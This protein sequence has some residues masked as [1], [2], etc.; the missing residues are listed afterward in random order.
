[1]YCYLTKSNNLVTVSEV[2]DPVLLEETETSSPLWDCAVYEI[3]DRNRTDPEPFDMDLDFSAD[4]PFEAAS[5]AGPISE[6]LGEWSFPEDCIA[7]L[8][9][10]GETE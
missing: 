1:M 2:D 10:K 3:N 7:F 9:T 4:S 8:L 5:G 6:Y